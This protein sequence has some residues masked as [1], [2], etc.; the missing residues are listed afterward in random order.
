M[1]VISVNTMMKITSVAKNVQAITFSLFFF[2]A[3]QKM[4]KYTQ[5]YCRIKSTADR[6]K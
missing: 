1:T 5:K 6:T 4:A 2:M 3:E